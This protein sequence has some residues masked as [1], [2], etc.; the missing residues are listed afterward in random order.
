M[1]SSACGPF[2]MVWIVPCVRLNES[3]ISGHGIL[4]CA[5]WS[6]LGFTKKGE[7]SDIKLSLLYFL[8]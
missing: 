5:Q 3:E 2:N 6:I 8:A 7:D 4:D 1:I